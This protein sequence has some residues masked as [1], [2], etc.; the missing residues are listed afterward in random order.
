MFMIEY[1]GNDESE[2]EFGIVY[3]ETWAGVL[4]AWIVPSR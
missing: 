1:W 3:G 4:V 2:Y